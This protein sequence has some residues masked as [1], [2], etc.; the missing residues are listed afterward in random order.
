MTVPL[1]TLHKALPGYKCC[2]PAC[3]Q[4][5]QAVDATTVA[6]PLGHTFPREETSLYAPPLLCSTNEPDAAP[7]GE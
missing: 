6:C 3:V 4:A 2:A 1:P 7:S 5:L